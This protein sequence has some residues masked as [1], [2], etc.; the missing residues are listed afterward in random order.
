MSNTQD[1]KA[2]ITSLINQKIPETD[3]AIWQEFLSKEIND[4]L[5]EDIKNGL[6]GSYEDISL[7]TNYLK[8]EAENKANGRIMTADDRLSV[9]KDMIKK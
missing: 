9:I 7:L 2:E 3:R 6:A 1:L 5:L 8:F 4:L